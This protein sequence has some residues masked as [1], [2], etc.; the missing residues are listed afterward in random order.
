MEPQLINHDYIQE[1]LSVAQDQK[2][3]SLVMHLYGRLLEARETFLKDP[4][5]AS[6]DWKTD[7]K[8]LRFELHKLKNQFANLGCVA[9]SQLLEQMYQIAENAETDLEFK[10][11]FE[12]FQEVSAMT[13]TQLR[14]ELRH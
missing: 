8:Q 6:I 4:F 10:T 14:S 9:A 3:D 12:R 7:R 5:F 11:L 1:L 2:E 13:L